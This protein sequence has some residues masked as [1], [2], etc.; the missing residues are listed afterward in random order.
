MGY[1][2]FRQAVWSRFRTAW[3]STTPIEYQGVEYTPDGSAY[4]KLTIIKGTG[5]QHSMGASS[6][7]YRHRDIIQV[8]VYT[9]LEQSP[10]E[11]NTLLDAVEAIF[12]GQTFSGI[13]CKDIQHYSGNLEEYVVDTFRIETQQDRI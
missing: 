4:V 7:P 8:D 12:K 5:S 6:N 1:D 3:G 13:S 10:V 9:P 2:D 11:A